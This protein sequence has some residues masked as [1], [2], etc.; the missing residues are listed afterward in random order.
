MISCKEYANSHLWDVLYEDGAAQLPFLS[1]NWVK[2]CEDVIRKIILPYRGGRLLDYGC[3][4]GMFLPLYKDVGFAE[5]IGIDTSSVACEKA[6]E[7]I[8]LEAEC[9]FRVIHGNSLKSFEGE[10]AKFDVIVFWGV[11]HHLPPDQTKSIITELSDLLT[12]N[13]VLIFS[14]WSVREQSRF[15]N[16]S[17]YG[18]SP[19]L[20]T[21]TCAIEAVLDCLY[22]TFEVLSTG[23]V[24]LAS[25]YF[26]YYICQ[27]KLGYVQSLQRELKNGIA[28]Y[29][30]SLIFY[31]FV[32]YSI[33]PTFLH[34]RLDTNQSHI[35]FP[36]QTAHLANQIFGKM[37]AHARRYC[38]GASL[39]QELFGEGQ[40]KSLVVEVEANAR[41]LYVKEYTRVIMVQFL[42]APSSVGRRKE[43][44]NTDAGSQ[45]AVIDNQEMS[46]NEYAG[47][48][49]DY[50]DENELLLPYGELSKQIN[51]NNLPD[52]ILKLLYYALNVEQDFFFYCFVNNSYS[53]KNK[54]IGNGGLIVFAKKP[55]GEMAFL[56]IDQLFTRWATSLSI[57]TIA[58]ILTQKAVQSAI[59][60]I[61]S[62]NGS[63][64]IGSHVLAA[65]SHNT[66][67]MP[68]DRVLYQYIQHRMDYM[69]TATT[70]FPTWR[71]PTRLLGTMMKTFLS[72]RHLLDHIA[73]S[74][75]LKGWKFQNRN[76]EKA[77]EKTSCIKLHLYPNVQDE[78]GKW[79]RK[80]KEDG[81][82]VDC[83]NYDT[84]C[85]DSLS[86]DVSLAIPGGT[87]GQ[88]AFF[89]IIEN[90]I[91]NAAKHDWSSPPEDKSEITNNSSECAEKA[92]ADN[93][94][95]NIDFADIA[96]EGNVL[97]TISTNLS[98]AKETENGRTLLD[99]ISEKLSA[100]FID[101][102]GKLRREN[103]GLAEMKISAGY[104][105]GREA[106]VIGG[107]E[108][109][110][111][112]ARADNERFGNDIIYPVSQEGG[113]LGYRFKVPKARTLLLVT[114]KK[115][116]LESGVVKFLAGKGIYVKSKE[117]IATTWADNSFEF[118]LVNNPQPELGDWLPS[119]VVI[120]MESIEGIIKSLANGSY[121]PQEVINEVAE[122]YVRQQQWKEDVPLNLVVAPFVERGQGKAQGS[123]QGLVNEAAAMTFVIENGFV[124]AVDSFNLLYPF[125]NGQ[126]A[127]TETRNALEF[128]KSK[129]LS[130]SIAD[131][132]KH[133]SCKNNFKLMTIQFKAW[134]KDAPE[135]AF[136]SVHGFIEHGGREPPQFRRF[137]RYFDQVCRQAK[138]YLGLYAEQIATL[139]KGFAHNSGDKCL[140]RGMEWENKRIRIFKVALPEEAYSPSL[141]PA[142][143][144]VR[145]ETV[146]VSEDNLSTF[147]SNPF[148]G[149]RKQFRYLEP[150]S[151]SQSY[152]VQLQE[153]APQ[154]K[155]LQ[156]KLIECA[157]TRILIVDERVSKFLATHSA[158][159]RA[160]FA[161]MGISVAD[162]KATDDALNG[163]EVKE[164]I[165]GLFQL[166][167]EE[168][169][170]LQADIAKTNDVKSP[171]VS[172]IS[173][174]NR[175]EEL[176]QKFDVLIIHQ[177]ILDKWFRGLVDNKDKMSLLIS[178][179]RESFKKV[180]ITTGRGTPA[181]I[182][183]KA[184]VLPFSTIE[185]TLFRK[186]PEKLILVDAIMNILPIRRN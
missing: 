78:T 88:H 144:Y 60:S 59:G 117:E 116:N 156:A 133:S 111:E 100:Q 125:D 101:A 93:L 15:E 25:P 5:I 172:M 152:L 95:I 184:R 9:G 80:K 135:G 168:I 66:G 22:D 76:G 98:D 18:I 113:H 166:S 32:N 42:R 102:S 53:I 74:E 143:G 149:P 72:Q 131:E 69:A 186:Y 81:N 6:R 160:T 79:T 73:V 153:L 164:R 48:L 35:I 123:G 150:L 154:D 29:L 120:A 4:P 99:R 114:D 176:Q 130:E 145:H 163:L 57:K 31:H 89:T 147:V 146:T 183:D 180:I 142:V 182:P 136:P 19:V 112:K 8:G 109:V 178:G 23:T 16:G 118:V 171:C 165:A 92:K 181:N 161:R 47:L 128:F 174:K 39:T 65:L 62:R 121:E 49:P 37:M 56:E 139:P 134:L 68:D 12:E 10:S 132:L 82:I 55:L 87:V 107:M 96:E 108:G 43:D 44:H 127:D 138:G 155:T 104:L 38:G 54:E 7:I 173:R 151:G 83:I 170:A 175:H 24:D 13:G 46:L 61:M 97:F 85:M 126:E 40:N 67:T 91:R 148:V 140:I 14:G 51:C 11:A 141:A 64:N 106:S 162:D 185:T 41:F 159:I 103:W 27:K 70:D 33:D 28:K 17:L 20:G 45:V 50:S 86:S 179:L 30:D 21:K 84:G 52:K 119:R 26:D 75:G 77:P 1:S 177:G 115:V 167:V 137:R 3:G 169:K 58:T 63:H 90:I 94:E 129:A 105:Q 36:A 157:L 2:P 158:D 110:S 34:A 124:E 122:K 71:Q